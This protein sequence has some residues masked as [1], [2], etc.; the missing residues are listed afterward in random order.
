MT[1]LRR[2]SS[3]AG[4]TRW[5][6]LLQLATAQQLR[7]PV[8]DG[9]EEFLVEVEEVRGRQSLSEAHIR[10]VLSD[11]V[12]RTVRSLYS[13]TAWIGYWSTVTPEDRCVPPVVRCDMET[14]AN[15]CALVV[16]YQ[17]K[18]MSGQTANTEMRALRELVLELEAVDDSL[19]YAHVVHAL[20]FIARGHWQSGLSLA[21]MALGIAMSLPKKVDEDRLGREAAYLAAIA[22]RRAATA[23]TDLRVSRSLLESAIQQESRG[24]TSD[25]RF[26][27]ERCSI[28]V[29]DMYFEGLVDG[30]VVRPEATRS[31]VLRL[32]ALLKAVDDEADGEIAR[33]VRRET[34]ANFFS[35]ALTLGG[36]D[37]LMGALGRGELLSHLARF[38]ALLNTDV[39]SG[40]GREVDRY[41]H[42][43]VD[44]A[45]AVLRPDAV[46]SGDA[47]ERALREIALW[48]RPSRPYDLERNRR[49]LR[50]LS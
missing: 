48:E 5:T 44:V 15:A 33:W 22:S 35:V 41:S 49:L 23:R 25:V 19:Y 3:S 6:L 26:E 21:R 13:K 7:N 16:Q 17:L 20:G 18:A 38:R 39:M 40:L 30:D 45:D 1:A 27:C 10:R 42:L 9:V 11:G 31:M 50:L 36:P 12:A 29:R 37:V 14:L 47:R 32:A 4:E 34:F 43:V 24:S 8:V 2:G 28:D 46:G